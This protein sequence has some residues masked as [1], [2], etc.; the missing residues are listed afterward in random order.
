MQSTPQARLERARTSLQGLSVGDAFGENF[1]VHWDLA[2][3]LMASG[4][5]EGPPLNFEDEGA[6]AQLIDERNLEFFPAPWRWT[7]DSAMAI[8]IVANLA[9]FGHIE[10]DALARG[11]A[12]RYLDDPVTRAYG[13]GMGEL[14]PKLQTGNWRDEAG[15]LFGGTG[16]FGNGAAMRAAPIGAYFADDP[17]LAAQNAALSAI[18]T[19]SHP[20]GVAGAVAAAMAACFAAQ[21]SETPRTKRRFIGDILP[22][23]EDSDVKDSVRHA[24]GALDE[25]FSVVVPFLG[26]GSLISAPDTV[27]FCLWCA[28]HQ[29]DDFEEALWL[30]VA[31]LG[32]RDTTCAIVGGIVAANVG[33]DKIPAQWREKRES[34]PE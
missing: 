12:R 20:E 32:D 9:E 6:I 5:V 24:R 22:F 34:L 30:T 25:A 13:S 2:E 1:F 31:G 7:D 14:L 8:E 26:N 17:D 21:Q 16:S 10:P 28:A 19:H 18:V 23:L 15:A 4:R 3:R 29:L 33:A 11:F 27:P